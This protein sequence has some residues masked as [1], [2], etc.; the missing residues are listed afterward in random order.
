MIIPDPHDENKEPVPDHMRK[1]HLLGALLL[2][3]LPSLL[4]ILLIKRLSV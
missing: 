1:W 3:V 2:L 4:G